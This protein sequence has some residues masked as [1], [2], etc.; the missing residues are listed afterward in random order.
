[1]IRYLAEYSDFF[2]PLR[3]LDSIT[4][5]AVV[6]VA[7]GFVLAIFYAKSFIRFMLGLRATEDVSKPDSA[8]LH[9][10]HSG[11]SGTPTMGG[12]I[13]LWAMLLVVPLVC[14]ITKPIVWL[15]LGV[16]L[17][18]GALG[19]VDDYM[20]L[21]GLGARGLT[22]RQKL[23][24]QFILAGI[25]A[26]LLWQC[27]EGDCF[28]VK[29][30]DLGF[31]ATG[32]KVDFSFD[33]SQGMTK[34]LVPFT[35][36]VEVQ[37]DLGWFYYVFFAFVLVACSNA[38]NL[39]DGL[40]GLAPGCSIMVAATYSIIAYVVGNSVISAF[41]RIPYVPGSGELSI[42]CA[43]A[44]GATMGFLWFNSHPAE[45]FLGDTG[46]LSLGAFTAYVALATKHE[47]VLIVAGGVF[48]LEAV[49]VLLQTASF[50]LTGKR[51]FKCAPF[52]HHLEFSGWHENKVV[53]RLWMISAVLAGLALGTLKMH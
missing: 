19:F 9:K 24:C 22:K 3:M 26:A 53:V 15:G 35:K 18:F 42:F 1:M 52:H 37:P 50:K 10:L 47:L 31:G 28:H 48:V 39:T 45:V 16:L 20:K 4:L 30:G 43:V 13:V 2:G 8:H 25:F 29:S 6:G 21:K 36:W 23:A 49:S 40:D 46:S 14:D 51:I 41:F 7:L 17:S 44:V 32:Y 27:V 34:L 12:L 5:R 33:D 38:V 11:K